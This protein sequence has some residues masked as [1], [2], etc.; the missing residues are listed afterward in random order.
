[1]DLD[2][3]E[4]LPL[5]MADHNRLEQIF[6]NLVSNARDAMD[7]QGTG[8]EKRLTIRTAA[9]GEHVI[10]TVTDTGKGMSKDVLEKIFEP[11]FTTKEIGKGTGLGL[12]I[13]YNLVT[14]FKGSIKA[15]SDLGAGTTF[16]LSFPIHTEEENNGKGPAHR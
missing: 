3:E 14:K 12:S 2:L 7:T 10:A 9:K 8:R 11:F 4:G 6:L 16:T 1:V 15:A 13:T 5:I